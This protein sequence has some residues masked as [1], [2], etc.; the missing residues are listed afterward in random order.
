MLNPR[1]LHNKPRLRV[2]LTFTLFFISLTFAV[3][4]FAP[5]SGAKRAIMQ[6]HAATGAAMLRGL[7]SQHCKRLLREQA[8]LVPLQDQTGGAA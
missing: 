5:R 6:E 1:S 2:A 7:V 3:I 4:A 8:Q